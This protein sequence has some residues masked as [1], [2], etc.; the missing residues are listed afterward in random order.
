METYI[1][2]EIRKSYLNHGE[3]ANFYYYRD[4]NQNEIDLMILQGGKLH[5]IECKSGV[6]FHKSDVSSLNVVKKKTQYEIGSMSIVCNTK[7]IYTLGDDVF[8]LP[9]S[10]I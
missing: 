1:V 4:S 5:F 3:H 8:V 10:A 7:T 2:N 6:S 9:I